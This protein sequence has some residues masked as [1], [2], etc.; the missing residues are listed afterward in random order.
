M[1]PS[2]ELQNMRRLYTRSVLSEETAGS[3]PLELF[4]LWF[5][6]AKTEGEPEPNAMSLATVDKSGQPSA[7]IVLL[8]GLIRDEFQFFTNYGSDKGKDIAENNKV[9]LN[10]FWPKLERQIRI[11]GLASPISKEESKAYFQ[12]RP[13]ESQIGALTSNQSSVVPSREF[14]E[15]KFAALTK[16]WEGKE[17]PMPENWGGYSVFPTKIEFWQGRVGRLHD[18]IQFVR[19]ESGWE[20]SRLSP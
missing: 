13:R 11:E 17:V 16:E 19:K 7:R 2:N 20:R 9:A 3:N 12:V 8:K 4:N 15:E 5:S 6:E 10:F 18:R 14:L 1:E